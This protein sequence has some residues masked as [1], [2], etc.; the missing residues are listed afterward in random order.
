M[1]GKKV[2]GLSV[3][4]MSCLLPYVKAAPQL[5]NCTNYGCLI[6]TEMAQVLDNGNTGC[7]LFQTQT[8]RKLR[9]LLGHQGNDPSV[10]PGTQT[11]WYNYVSCAVC[12]PPMPNTIAVDSTGWNNLPYYVGSFGKYDCRQ[13]GGPLP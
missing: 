1:F 7:V 3:V 5:G 2:I 4:I 11:I 9:N 8:G 6:V 10:L 12:N 13:V